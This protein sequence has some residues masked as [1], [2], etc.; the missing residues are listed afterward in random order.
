MASSGLQPRRR[1]VAPIGM[2]FGRIYT[3]RKGNLFWQQ[4]S[5]ED[6]Y[7][8]VV[9]VRI[10]LIWKFVVGKEQVGVRLSLDVMDRSDVMAVRLEGISACERVWTC[11]AGGDSRRKMRRDGGVGSALSAGVRFF[12]GWGS[13]CCGLLGARR[14]NE[15][16]SGSGARSEQ[17]GEI[18]CW[19]GVVVWAAGGQEA[20][21]GGMG[22]RA[23][24]RSGVGG[25]APAGAVFC[26]VLAGRVGVP[27]L[28]FAWGAGAF[29]PLTLFLALWCGVWCV[30]A[31]RGVWGGG[32]Q[33]VLWGV[34]VP[35]LAWGRAQLAL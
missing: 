18:F 7:C 4:D 33:A 5:G 1:P 32:C 27:R 22:E 29:G 28:A 12:A 14:R 11:L 34:C 31:V 30:V 25:L 17:W 6:E 35:C 9:G 20:K 26:A 10:E 23:E 19:A 24:I 2:G 13:S 8:V 16:G 3:D 21:Q 15:A